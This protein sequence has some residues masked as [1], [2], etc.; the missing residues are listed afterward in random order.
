MLRTFAI[1]S[2]A[3]AIL[4]A[5][6]PQPRFSAGVQLVE[7]Y[8]GV[9]DARGEPIRNLT[10][11][12]FVVTEDGQPQAVTA[13]AAGEFPLSVTVGV[14]RSWSMG[15]E[16]FTKAKRAARELLAQLK[17]DDR[18][19]VV[20]IGGD[21]AIVAPMGVDRASQDRA[22]AALDTWGTTPLHDAIMIALDR[23]EP[24]SGRQALVVFSD[25][26]DRY[27]E[28]S[29]ADV[30]ARARRSRALIYP[31]VLGTRKLPPLLVEL[32]VL[33]G[34]RTLVLRD[35]TD[36]GKDGIARIVRELHS[37]YLLGYAPANVPPA[38]T[39]AWRSIKVSLRN[40]AAGMRV[41]AR[42]GYLT[43]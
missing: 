13:F 26:S 23:L 15:G 29:A 42:D 2:L 43:D 25:G 31:V 11:A 24:E 6:E 5:Q 35:T 20:A 32:A 41:R 21:A 30:L 37:Q 16:A 8:A 10:Q 4:L 17:P 14:D 38:G 19:M 1:G 40:P 33:T 3:S 18:S 22:I 36:A 27:S 9:T 7:V 28:T 39:H 12:D 34:G